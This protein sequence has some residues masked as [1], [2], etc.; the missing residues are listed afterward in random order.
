MSE[1]TLRFDTL[2]CE[3]TPY[4]IGLAYSGLVKQHPFKKNYL[5]SDEAC[6]LE[7]LRAKNTLLQQVCPGLVEKIQGFADGMDV[8]ALA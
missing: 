1:H 2:R 5:L 8:S 6:S 7:K 3:G 4:N